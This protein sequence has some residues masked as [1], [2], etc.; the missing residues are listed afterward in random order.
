MY[1]D[2]NLMHHNTM[3]MFNKEVLKVNHSLFYIYIL[4]LS[5]SCLKM[6]HNKR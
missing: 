2:K 1:E 6:A 5:G 4:P 3:H